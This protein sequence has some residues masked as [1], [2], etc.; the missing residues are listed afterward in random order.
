MPSPQYSEPTVRPYRRSQHNRSLLMAHTLSLEVILR[1][2][3]GLR[4]STSEDHIA[5]RI[6]A[7][8]PR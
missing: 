4:V 6:F 2:G 1:Y 5:M 3:L 8:G 7:D